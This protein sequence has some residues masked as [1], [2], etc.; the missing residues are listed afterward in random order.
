MKSKQVL[1]LGEDRSM[2]A[3][4]IKEVGRGEARNILVERKPFGLFWFQDESGIYVGIDNRSGEAYTELFD[5]KDE[6]ITW[7]T[8]GKNAQ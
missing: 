2:F 1:T 8:G 5:T 4:T 6:C 7:L 3:E